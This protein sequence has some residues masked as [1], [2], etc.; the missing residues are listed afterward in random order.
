ML[1]REEES[2]KQGYSQQLK[3]KAES[4]IIQEVTKQYQRDRAQLND[5]MFSEEDI[6]KLDELREKVAAGQE[7]EIEE[8]IPVRRGNNQKVAFTQRPYPNLAA[9]DTFPQVKELPMPKSKS[10]KA[11]AGDL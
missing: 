5:T 7:E 11:S 4:K 9:R 8:E 6:N 3:Q 1:A 10:S 2:E